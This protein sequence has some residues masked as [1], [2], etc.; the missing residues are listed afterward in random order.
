MYNCK[1]V[2]GRAIQDSKLRAMLE[3]LVDGVCFLFKSYAITPF[4]F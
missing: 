2:E 1:G 3:Q 4:G